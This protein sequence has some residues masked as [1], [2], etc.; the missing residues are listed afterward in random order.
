[1][2]V[3]LFRMISATEETLFTSVIRFLELLVEVFVFAIQFYS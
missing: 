2:Y 1:M 3:I